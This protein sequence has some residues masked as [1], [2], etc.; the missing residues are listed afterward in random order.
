MNGAMESPMQRAAL[1]RAVYLPTLWGNCTE[2]IAKEAPMAMV[3]P[4]EAPMRLMM[5]SP[6]KTSWFVM[7]ARAPNA[8]MEMEMRAE[9]MRKVW[10][11]PYFG[12][13]IPPT[14]QGVKK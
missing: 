6:K 14:K 5:A 12:S 4:K 8:N 2:T 13:K 9:P 11:L 1:K 7:K 10:G 3:L